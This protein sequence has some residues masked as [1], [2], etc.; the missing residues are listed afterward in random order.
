M[1]KRF[2]AWIAPTSS[3]PD[4]AYRQVLLKGLLLFLIGAEVLIIVVSV[5]PAIMQQRN[6]VTVIYSGC[7]MLPYLLAYRF[8]QQGRVKLAAYITSVAIFAIVFTTTLVYGESHIAIVGVGVAVLITTTLL[9][10]KPASISV[11][12][13]VGVLS[14]AEPIR[15]LFPAIVLPTEM[16]PL[17]DDVFFAISLFVLVGFSW[18]ATRELFRLV[19]QERLLSDKLREHSEELEQMVQARTHELQQQ[20]EALQTSEEQY[21]TLVRN[22]PDGAVFLF[23]HDLRY[24]VA[25]GT[26][27]PSMLVDGQSIENKTI[28]EAWRPEITLEVEKRYRACLKG[29]SVIVE[30]AIGNRILSS[31][32]LPIRNAQG[33]VV[34]GMSVVQN[35]TERKQAEEKVRKLESL[36]RRAIVA[37]GAVPYQMDTDASTYLFIGEGIQALTGYSA[38]EIT[39]E[40]WQSLIQE[41]TSRGALAG[42]SREEAIAKVRS[43]LVDI[44]TGDCRIMVQGK[45]R[46]VADVSVELR[47]EQGHSIGSIG[48]LQ[49]ITDRKDAEQELIKAKE[50]AEAAGQAKAEFLANMSHEI[51]TPLNAMIGMT[52]VLL[53]TPLTVEQSD[54][55]EIIRNSGDTLLG[56]INDILDFSKIESGKL[57]LEMIPFDLVA[58]LEET[59]DL[60]AAQADQ[61]SLN[62]VYSLDPDVPLTLVGDPTRLRQILT[63][64]VGNAIKFTAQGEVVV[65]VAVDK[66][67][68]DNSPQSKH[69]T[70]HFAVRDTGIGISTEGI[71]RLFQSFSQV[72]TSTTRRFGGSG[73]GLAISLRLSQLMGG[74]LW[75]ES[76]PGAGSTF[77]F[78]I[79]AEESPVEI[80]PISA[81]PASLEGKRVLLVDDHLITLDILSRQLRAWHMIPVGVT[82]GAAAL[83]KVAAGETFDLAILDRQMPEMD[84]LDLAAQLREEPN[85]GK[86]PLVML[87]SIGNIPS[88]SKEVNF[89]AV[90]DKPVKQAHLQKLLISVLSEEAF[91]RTLTPTASRF[92]PT[93]AHRLPLRILLAEDNAVNQKVARH[94]LSRLGYRVDVAGNGEEVLAALERQGYDVVLMDVQMPEMDGL[95][96]TRRIHAQWP[97]EQVPYIVAMTAYALMGDAEKCLAAGMNDYISKPVQLEKLVHALEQS[98][99]SLSI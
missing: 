48:L 76:E 46:W 61:K 99:K 31:H 16:T 37:A 33:E 92:D 54:F 83:A 68:A 14:V 90:L 20:A 36:Y 25:G 29:E 55:T 41:H 58:C 98:Q 22:F 7:L 21:R 11:L 80:R 89:A 18:F 8:A 93:M 53:D 19:S 69:I 42:L 62:L 9:G 97:P 71:T 82:S 74:K 96:A 85:G 64:L 72:D 60:F 4:I 95:E 57:D 39:P 70:L 78:T 32:V 81:L 17:Q 56:L 2:H 30:S 38:Q 91:A 13:S 52:S 15:H 73:L 86:L 94:M 43:G 50:A 5:I 87:S 51:R 88:R 66:G 10:V 24:K 28:W 3:D 75:V 79:Q 77:H 26:L 59:L 35:I 1:I 34:G 63:N 40:L 27:L 47:D 6:W 44:W 45:E 12:V 49:D 23:D 84:G 67:M 65:T